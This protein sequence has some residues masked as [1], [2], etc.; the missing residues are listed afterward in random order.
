MNAG[1]LSTLLVW[2]AGLT[3]TIALVA[4]TTV[5]ARIAEARP[6]AAKV[7]AAG[8]TAPVAA[9]PQISFDPWPFCHTSVM[10]PHAAPTDRTLS[11]TALTGSRKERKAR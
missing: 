6:R 9:M 7:A 10:T 1:E 2:A 4:Y 5:L 8:A 11:T 3:Y